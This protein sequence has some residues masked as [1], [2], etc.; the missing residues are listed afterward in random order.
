MDAADPQAG[1]PLR[2]VT[3]EQ[4]LSASPQTGLSLP[5]ALG[6]LGLDAA[7][8]QGLLG[9]ALRP[10]LQPKPGAAAGLQVSSGSVAKW[11]ERK[12]IS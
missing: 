5:G 9:P 12:C 2:R 4:F 7:C 1:L 3:T 6:H 8:L 11:E 10:Q